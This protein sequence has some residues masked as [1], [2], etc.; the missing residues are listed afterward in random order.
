MLSRWTAFA[1][2]ALG[3]GT[4]IAACD[5]TPTGVGCTSTSTRVC[6][7]GRQFEPAV[8]E[9]PLHTSVTW[10]NDTDEIH[11]VTSAT[12]SSDPFDSGDIAGGSSALL[13]FSTIG[14]FRYYCEYHGQDANP[15]TGMWATIIVK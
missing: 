5:V 14:T 11:T 4:A 12:G 8:I 3:A 10:R 13:T 6:I 1:A 15:P 7:V 2:V 9:V